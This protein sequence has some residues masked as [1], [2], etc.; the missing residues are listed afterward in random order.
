MSTVSSFSH[1]FNH[2]H[3]LHLT[4]PYSSVLSVMGPEKR[5]VE[6]CS[7]LLSGVFHY[8]FCHQRQILLSSGLKEVP[9]LIAG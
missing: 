8:Y 7:F 3:L 2:R 9:L 1:Q 6:C 4:R 5:H